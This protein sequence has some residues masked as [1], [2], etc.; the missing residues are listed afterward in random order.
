MG[1]LLGV[2]HEHLGIAASI[3]THFAF[4]T[5]ALL[6]IRPLLSVRPYI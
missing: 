3:A 1:L 6:L 5:T 4:D 2:G